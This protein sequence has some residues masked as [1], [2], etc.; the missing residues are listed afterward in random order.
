MFVA[1]IPLWPHILAENVKRKK[2]TLFTDKHL[3]VIEIYNYSKPGK[4]PDRMHS[5]NSQSKPIITMIIY[6][7]ND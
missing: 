4:K 7:W 3:N 2:I 5:K 6:N 1:E